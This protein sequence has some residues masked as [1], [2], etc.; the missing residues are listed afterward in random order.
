MYLKDKLSLLLGWGNMQLCKLLPVADF[1][2]NK[3][4]NHYHKAVLIPQ[5]FVSAPAPATFNYK[6]KKSFWIEVLHR[7]FTSAEVYAATIY[8]CILIGRGVILNEQKKI[9]LEST[10]FQHE[11]LYK[12]RNAHLILKF[13]FICPAPELDYI[14]P[15]LSKLSNNYYH[16]TIENLTRVVLLNACDKHFKTKYSIVI[17][18]NAPAFIADSLKYL[19][20]WPEDKIIKWQDNQAASVNNC[21]LISYPVTRNEETKMIYGYPLQIYKLLNGVAFS[22]IQPCD[23]ILPEYFIISRAKAKFRMLV[24]ES[25]IKAALSD[26][27]VEIIHLESLSYVQQVQLF[28]K[29]KLVIAPH[30]AGLTNIVYCNG[31]SMIIELCP[32]KEN[33]SQPA[34]FYQIARALQIRYYIYEVTPCNSSNDMIADEI[35]ISEIKNQ[36]KTQLMAVA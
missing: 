20:Q 24:N 6:V 15:L 36:V 25:A 2:K 16:W 26:Y 31:Q 33:Y 8:N 17:A 28:Q 30:G 32:E 21:L 27:P 3:A 10:F 19:L 4:L 34:L 9:L 23:K 29:A 13:L 11:Y 5:H 35:L 18:A 1:R 7:G 22:N 12:L 14:I